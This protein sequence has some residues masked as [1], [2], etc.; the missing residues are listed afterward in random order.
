MRLLLPFGGEVLSVVF[1][2]G[3]RGIFWD[4]RH[5][6]GLLTIRKQ[7]ENSPQKTSP[8]HRA[9]EHLNRGR[10]IRVRAVIISRNSCKSDNFLRFLL[11]WK[12]RPELDSYHYAS[13]PGA[14]ANDSQKSEFHR[15][16]H[17]GSWCPPISLLVYDWPGL[18]SN[19]DKVIQSFLGDAFLHRYGVGCWATTR[20]ATLRPRQAC[21]VLTAEPK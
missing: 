3:A 1:Q 21:R 10:G 13:N 12:D 15:Y 7:R 5:L 8:A 4:F 2:K 20:V 19:H 16:Y 18:D 14:S 17:L 6:N 9:A 11:R